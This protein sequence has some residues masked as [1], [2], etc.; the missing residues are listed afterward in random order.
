MPYFVYRVQPFAQLEALGHYASFPE[1]SRQ[2]K[3]I[4][5]ATPGPPGRRVRVIFAD[6]ALQAEDL[7]LQ[8]RDP[9]P[10]GEDD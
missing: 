10:G 1:A 4:R 3:A 6:D 5:A 2:A 9:L 8:V 7:L